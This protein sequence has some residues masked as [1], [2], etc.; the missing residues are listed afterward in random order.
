MLYFRVEMKKDYISFNTSLENFKNNLWGH[1]LVVPKKIKEKFV[2]EKDRRVLIK[3][4]GLDRE[5]PCAIMYKGDEYYFINL[6]KEI[7]KKLKLEVGAKVSVLIRKDTSEYGMPMPEELEEMFYQDPEA[8]KYFKKLTPGKQRNLI[9][10][11]AKPKTEATRIK[12][13]LV[14]TDYLKF[15]RGQLDFKELNQA[16]KDFQY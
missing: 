4:E 16:F 1:H 12:K 7:R 6:N 5:I 11:V 15:S 2:S 14:I 10:L 8:L 9:Y 13:A 3:L